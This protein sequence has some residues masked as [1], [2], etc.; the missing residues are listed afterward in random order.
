MRILL[1]LKYAGVIDV[2][3]I[4]W[5][6]SVPFGH[7]GVSLRKAFTLNDKGFTLRCPLKIAVKSQQ[8]AQVSKWIPS[9]TELLLIQQ[10]VFLRSSAV[11]ARALRV[12]MTLNRERSVF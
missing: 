2:A 7:A 1:F 11:G 5:Q 8:S 10:A 12:S 6:S 9:E 3:S 4:F